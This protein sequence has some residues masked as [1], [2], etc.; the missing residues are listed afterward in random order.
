[1]KNILLILVTLIGFIL[2]QDCECEE[3]KDVWFKISNAEK[4][5]GKLLTLDMSSGFA[6]T[7]GLFIYLVV[8]NMDTGEDLVVQFPI[9]YWIIDKI[10]KK[11][12][13]QEKKKEEEFD[14]DEYLK[15]NKGKGRMINANITKVGD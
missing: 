7:D 9:G 12:P 5:Y 3:P 4:D 6:T 2:P 14:L 13:K 10:D 1:M 8:K 11:I 15:K